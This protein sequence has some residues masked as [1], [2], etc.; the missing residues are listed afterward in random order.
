MSGLAC[1]LSSEV[2]SR[3]RMTPLNPKILKSL[4]P[5][6]LNAKSLSPK[7]LSPACNAKRG[8]EAQSTADNPG[9]GGGAI[10]DAKTYWLKAPGLGF[11][12]GFRNPKP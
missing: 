2:M 3:T 1:Y 4:N 6:Y 10:L 12:P 11:I 7:S 5:K 9:F 8:S